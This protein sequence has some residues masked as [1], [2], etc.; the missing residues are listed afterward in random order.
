MSTGFVAVPVK[1]LNTASDLT[2]ILGS[3]AWQWDGT[4]D[5]RQPEERVHGGECDVYSAQD[6]LT[7]TQARSRPESDNHKGSI[8][9]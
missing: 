7:E 5:F 6:V 1:G 4:A 8:L 2:I 3:E 9:I